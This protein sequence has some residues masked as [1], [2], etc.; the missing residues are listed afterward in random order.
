[1]KQSAAWTIVLVFTFF[2][3]SFGGNQYS[4]TDI[5]NMITDLQRPA[6]IPEKGEVTQ[7]WSSYDRD[8]K[9][10]E[11]TGK[12]I[13]WAANGDGYGGKN[14][15]RRELGK[16]VVAEM[17]GPGCVWRFWV[18]TAKKG[19]VTIYLDGDTVPVV[20][21][22]CEDYFNCTQEPFNRPQL[23]HV[24]A[25]GKNSYVPIS[26]QK[27]CKIVMD[28]D[29]GQY[30]QFT[31]S[32]FPK[33]T[34]VQTFKRQ[35]SKEEG[36]ALDRVNKQLAN[37]GPNFIAAAAG[38]KT[39]DINVTIGPGE[40][41]TIAEIA[42][43]RAITSFVIKNVFTKDVQQ[44]RDIIREL[45]IQIVWDGQKNAAVWVPLGD[46]FGTAAGLNNHKSLTCGVTD[47]CL[48]ANWFM[49]FAKTA[50]LEIINDGKS[51][52]TLPIQ[53]KHRPVSDIEKYGRFH[54]KWHR[55]MFLPKEPE[56]EIDWTLLKTQGS[57]RFVGVE[58][59]IW[60]PMGGW[61]GEGD[62]K[63][64]VD[65]EKFPSTYGTGS[66][67]YFGYAWSSDQLFFHPLHNQTI[68]EGNKGHISDN[69][70]Q[71]GD[72]IPF[73]KSFDG[74]IEKY[75]PNDKPTLYS[76]VVY[77]YLSA[78]GQDPYMP[79]AMQDR[80]GWYAP[81]KFPQNIAGITV[82]EKPVG[83]IENEGMQTFTADKW[84][85]NDQLWWTGENGAKLRLGI[86]VKNAGKHKIVT[87]LT[88]AVDFGIIQ[89][90]LDGKKVGEPMD[91]FYATG[92][93]ATKEI[94][95]GNFNLTKGQHELTVE[96]VGANPAAIK[97]YMVG[98]DYIKVK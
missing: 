3:I 38:E 67:D 71:I 36:E 20:D 18:A 93:I 43:P 51:Q 21:L 89:W 83:S 40:K 52:I 69:R 86:D 77:W 28:E 1:M 53:I 88:K 29:Y 94:T 61:W 82:L 5:I 14:W 68:S 76:C 44:Q 79:V 63:F 31:Y 66:E 55:D 98:I 13:N 70:W 17:D 24:V 90:Y 41:K 34:K 85:N 32:L 9:Y 30:Y 78:D 87:R 56:R 59:E 95:L 97:R 45:A 49:P 26:F 48:Y 39:E 75:F 65:G 19:H 57:G 72:S 2:N 84:E 73:Q 12:Y 42:G 50:K 25:N 91:L 11:K 16:F 64:F 47:E 60:N 8:S 74:Y 62:E 7:Q 23:V 22:P 81:I 54:A 33:G 35:L 92:V 46:F 10:D 80:L 15:L 58:L 6:L 37:A 96:I 27:S 4:Y